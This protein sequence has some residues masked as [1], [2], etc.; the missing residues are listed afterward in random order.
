MVGLIWPHAVVLHDTFFND[1]LEGMLGE[2]DLWEIPILLS[3][4]QIMHSNIT[5]HCL[6]QQYS[7][8]R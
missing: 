8:Q 6:S 4:L 1:I 2:V 5:L 7:H 3:C